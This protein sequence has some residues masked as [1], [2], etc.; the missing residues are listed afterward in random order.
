MKPILSVDQIFASVKGKPLGLLS[1]GNFDNAKDCVNA[2]YY[3]QIDSEVKMKWWW[4][5]T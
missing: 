2:D 4:S 3:V 1:S 5:L